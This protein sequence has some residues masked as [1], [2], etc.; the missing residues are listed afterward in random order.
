[1][2]LFPLSF[3]P[4]FPL[5]PFLRFPFLVS[6]VG[7]HVVAVRGHESRKTGPVYKSRKQIS[8]KKRKTKECVEFVKLVGEASFRKY[9]N[10]TLL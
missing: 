8:K 10:T 1:M 3:V 7:P 4:C 6:V 2:G 5:V 9:G